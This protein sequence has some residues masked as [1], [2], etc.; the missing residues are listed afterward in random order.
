MA[1]HSAHHVP[2]W[3][4]H[5]VNLDSPATSFP[6][7]W[8][9][10]TSKQISPTPQARNKSDDETSRF[11]IRTLGFIYRTSCFV[12]KHYLSLSKRDVLNTERDVLYMGNLNVDRTPH[13]ISLKSLNNRGPPK[14]HIAF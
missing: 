2:H 8:H 9:S 14:T 12:T 13:P 3:C 4:E 6:A 11:I 1:N 7:N 10:K 5:P